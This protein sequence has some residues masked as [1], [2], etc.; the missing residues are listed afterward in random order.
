MGKGRGHYFRDVL[1]DEKLID[2]LEH[3]LNCRL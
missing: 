3:R 2:V 1:N